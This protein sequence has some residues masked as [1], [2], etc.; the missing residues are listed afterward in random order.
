MELGNFLGRYSINGLMVLFVSFSKS[1]FSV[2]NYSRIVK[3]IDDEGGGKFC[4]SRG[5]K[6]IFVWVWY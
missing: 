4:H 5:S 2:L 3:A 1:W 6:L